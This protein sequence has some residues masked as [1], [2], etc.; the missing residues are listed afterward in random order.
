[1]QRLSKVTCIPSMP[2]FVPVEDEDCWCPPGYVRALPHWRLA[3]ATYFVT[4]RQADS[5]PEEVLVR[6]DEERA[7]WLWRHGID[8]QWEKTDAARFEAALMALPRE[9]K[10][11][12]Q[13]EDS[14]RFLQELDRCHGSCRLAV[15]QAREIVTQALTHFHGQRLWVGDLVVMPNHVHVIAQ[16]FD[17][18]KLEDWLYSVKRFSSAALRKA[19]WTREAHFRAGHFWQKESFDRVI[20]DT[21]ELQRTRDYIASNGRRLR[22][23]EYTHVRMEWLDGLVGG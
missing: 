19:G 6:W 14:K 7:A 2:R 13:R 3:G 8:V 9:V 17:G 18:V 23:D 21:A 22:A 20:R 16:P 12:R 11:A 4:F 10:T 5:L 15:P 1:M